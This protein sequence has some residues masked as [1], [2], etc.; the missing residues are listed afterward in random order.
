MSTTSVKLTTEQEGALRVLIG[1]ILAGKRVLVLAGAAGTGKTTLVRELIARLFESGWN[2]D[3]AAPTGKAAVRLTEVTGMAASTIHSLAFSN[4]TEDSD[5]KPIF[6]G[7]R[8]VVEDS[9]TVLIVDE[10]SMVGSFMAKVIEANLP[11]GCAVV[12]VGDHCQLQPVMDS[13]GVNFD[14]PDAVLSTVHRQALDNPIL[15]I[16]TELRTNKTPIPHGKVGAAYERRRWN[17]PAAARWF[18]ELHKRGEQV[19]ALTKT[20]RTRRGMNNL[21][22]QDLG[23]R[24]QG[25]L[26]AGD[27]LLIMHNNKKI[28][29]MNGEIVPVTKVEATTLSERMPFLRGFSDEVMQQELL[30]VYFDRG[31]ALVHPDLIGMPW[32]DVRSWASGVRMDPYRLAVCDYGFAVTGHKMQGSE[33]DVGLIVLDRAARTVS[34]RDPEDSR[35]WVYT[36]L[37]RFR[38]KILVVDT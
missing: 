38:K 34:M 31:G 35:R 9:R 14:E 4:V 37:T 19:V 22:R 15:R 28:G 20:N 12:Y 8:A 6:S 16:A 11:R 27:R 17:K 18:A 3:L 25:V 23:H 33:A 26:I 32:T 29:R 13:F 36:A 24:E 7:Q 5:G 30:K 1:R 2:V 10:A 21:I